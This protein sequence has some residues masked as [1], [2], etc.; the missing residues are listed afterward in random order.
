ME[1]SIRKRIEKKKKKFFKRKNNHYNNE[2]LKKI[3]DSIEV[4][5][6]D[7]LYDIP[8]TCYF[9]FY[10]FLIL[11]NRLKFLNWE[12]R[13]AYFKIGICQD[14]NILELSRQTGIC[15]NSIRDAYRELVKFK[16]IEESSIVEPEHKSTRTCLVYN[17]FFINCFEEELGHVIYNSKI[18]NDHS[19][20]DF[21][22]KKYGSVDHP[23]IN[24]SEF[25][26]S[27][28]KNELTQIDQAIVPDTI[29]ESPNS[30]Y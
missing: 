6:S 14:I 1:E 16:L 3:F 4:E 7:V 2:K 30:I 13:P 11:K 18:P 8:F 23:K 15:R 5:F 20:Y 26:E 10:L 29:K 25:R 17:D 19:T 22:E 21:L 28:S 12:K 24:Q 9:S 27:C